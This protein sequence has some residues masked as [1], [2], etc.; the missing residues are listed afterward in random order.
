[1]NLE[2]K[3]YEGTGGTLESESIVSIIGAKGTIRIP[4]KSYEGEK[5]IFAILTKENGE[6]C[7]VVCSEDVSKG[8]RDKS[9]TAKELASFVVVNGGDKGF[10]IARPSRGFIELKMENLVVENFVPSVVS[11]EDLA[12]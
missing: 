2:F 9:I 5:R 10:F 1:M 6:S 12:V 8:L 7:G 11:Y 3:K 4:R